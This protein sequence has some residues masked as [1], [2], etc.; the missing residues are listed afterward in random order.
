MYLSRLLL[1]P[2]NRQVISEISNRYELHRTLSAQFKDKKREDIGLLYRLEEPDLY[3]F[4]PLTLLVQT[5]IEPNWEK[6][7]QTGYLVQKAETKLYKPTFEP[8]EVFYFR[9]LANPTVRRGKGDFAGKRVELRLDE[10]REAWLARKGEKGGFT[11]RGMRSKD[12]GKIS[13]YHFI[14]GKKQTLTHQAVLYDGVLEVQAV[15]QFMTSLQKGI[16]PAKA[17]GFGLLSLA[18]G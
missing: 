15:E 1:D 7:Y 8:G 10:E 12:L 5:L 11:L 18:K 4:T 17:F 6:L 2:A 13:S 16:G 14:D 9:L 3:E